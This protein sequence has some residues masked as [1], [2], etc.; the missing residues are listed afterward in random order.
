[1]ILCA[2]VC[3]RLVA[4]FSSILYEPPQPS[5]RPFRGIDPLRHCI[6]VFLPLST[7]AGVPASQPASWA[8]I[9]AW[10]LIIPRSLIFFL[11]PARLFLAS[12]NVASLSAR[13][14]RLLLVEAA[15]LTALEEVEQRSVR[16]TVGG[17]TVTWVSASDGSPLKNITVRIWGAKLRQ[18]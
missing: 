5:S 14:S 13:R 3:Q 10:A 1:M 12:Q 11:S 8:R 18:T 6:Q 15:E 7:L 9:W 17:G 4:H 16:E 2:R